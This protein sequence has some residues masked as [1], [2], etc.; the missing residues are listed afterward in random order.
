MNIK[1]AVVLVWVGLLLA[2]RPVVAHHA[3]AAEFDAA[4]PVKLTGAVT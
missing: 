3:F 2:G 1:I 4:K